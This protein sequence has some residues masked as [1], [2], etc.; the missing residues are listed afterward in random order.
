[1]FF[2][3]TSQI[4]KTVKIE[5][6]SRFRTKFKIISLPTPSRFTKIEKKKGKIEKVEF[7]SSKIRVRIE[8][9]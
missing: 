5:L 2:R 3:N 8:K 9:Q 6:D 7:F 1:M 4:K